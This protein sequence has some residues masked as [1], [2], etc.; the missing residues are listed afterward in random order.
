MQVLRGAG[1]SV[2]LLLIAWPASLFYAEPQLLH[3]IPVIG[4]SAAISGFESTTRYTLNKEL[5]LGRITVMELGSQLISIPVMILW[6]YLWPSVWALVAGTLV[7][8]SV[9]MIWTHHLQRGR[10]NRLHWDGGAAREVIHFG[11]WIFA[12][13]ALGFLASQ[14]DRLLLGK[15]IPLEVL[16]VYAI[17]FA[18]IQIPDNLL[19]SLGSSVLF[20]A[21]TRGVDL[22]RDQL[23]AIIRRNRRP[24]LAALAAVAV[25]IAA[26]GDLG[27]YL[28]Y[29]D[30]Y[31]NAG[32][33]HQHHRAGAVCHRTAPLHCLLLRG[34]LRLP[35]HRRAR[36]ARLC[37]H[38]G[39]RDRC[40]RRKHRRLRGRELGIA[41]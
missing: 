7:S 30:R 36:G 31:R 5:A 18:L 12:T 29:D 15:L 38:A 22:P 26:L 1:I 2:C 23:R 3:V 28:L 19:G 17:S 13:S 32:W 14:V 6:A 20:P 9:R 34:A 27:V 21:I 4:L 40:R 24:L 37:W 35:D 25:A 39:R 11:K 16:G 41:A 33:R 10:R 8:S